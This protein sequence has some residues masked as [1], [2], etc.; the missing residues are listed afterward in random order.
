MT[1]HSVR[2]LAALF[3]RQ[4]IKRINKLIVVTSI[5]IIIIVILKVAGLARELG[6]LS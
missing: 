2:E 5:I 1:G 3:F 4:L 6:F